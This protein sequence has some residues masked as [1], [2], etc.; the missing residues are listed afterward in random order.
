MR[1]LTHNG[2]N[3]YLCLTWNLNPTYQTMKT[4]LFL[5]LGLFLFAVNTKAQVLELA[6]NIDQQNLTLNGESVDNDVINDKMLVPFTHNKVVLYQDN[7]LTYYADF[8]AKQCG[9][10]TQIISKTYVEKSDGSK[11]KGTKQKL[12][13]KTEKGTYNWL[14]SH[15]EDDFGD[16]VPLK[17]DFEYRV[18]FTN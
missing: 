1:S 12:K 8:K 6:V 17:S 5:T 2:L 15:Y 4:F 3:V 13:K 11:I 18:R 10:K 16:D 9:K 7:N 14:I